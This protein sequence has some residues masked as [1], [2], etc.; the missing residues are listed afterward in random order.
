[1]DLTTAPLA[2]F[3]MIFSFGTG[4]APTKN[5]IND[6]P[7]VFGIF[8]GSGLLEQPFQFMGYFPRRH[9]RVYA[10]GNEPLNSS[11]PNFNPIQTSI[12]VFVF[13]GSGQKSSH[14]LRKNKNRREK[15]LSKW[16]MI[17]NIKSLLS[18][19]TPTA[20]ILKKHYFQAV[21]RAEAGS[22]WFIKPK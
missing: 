5:T 11:K 8:R 18:D 14:N 20:S 22:F 16:L 13:R 6:S 7:E 17:L 12:L 21:T 9:R 1:M 15:H 2:P 4:L 10:S 3:W 19:S